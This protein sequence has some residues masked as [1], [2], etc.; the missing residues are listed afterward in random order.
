MSRSE[1]IFIWGKWVTLGPK[2]ARPCNYG[3]P[4]R[5]I[6]KFFTMKGLKSYMELVLIVFVKK[7]SFGANGPL[8]LENG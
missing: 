2:M 7:F 5:I 8:W 1:T 4:L 3:S 6:L